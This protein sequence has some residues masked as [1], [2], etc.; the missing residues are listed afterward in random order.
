MKKI[1]LFG[2][3]FDPVH[4]GHLAVG[5]AVV[6]RFSLDEV[7]FI[8]AASPPHKPGEQISG[9]SHR[10]AMLK[11]AIAEKKCFS[12]SEIEAERSG[13][14]FTIDTLALLQQRFDKEVSFFFITGLDAFAEIHTWKSYRKLLAATSFVVIDRPSHSCCDLKQI[15]A[16]RL[17][18]YAEEEP[19]VWKSPWQSRIY[20]LDMEPVHVSSTMIRERLKS[21]Q[22]LKGLL[23]SSVETYIHSQNLYTRP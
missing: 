21:G 16:L 1:G 2:G 22:T 7:V 8:P 14:S 20:S 4:N 17:A 9:F 11:L 15:I 6:D 3:T 18:A 10:L 5:Q 13:P 12:V 19:G 23:P